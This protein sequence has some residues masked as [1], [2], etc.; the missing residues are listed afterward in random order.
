MSSGR[1]WASPGSPSPIHG[2]LIASQHESSGLYVDPT[3]FPTPHPLP[4]ESISPSLANDLLACQLRVAFSRD[5]ELRSWRRPSTYSALGVAAHWVTE[6]AF[7]RSHWPTDAVQVRNRLVEL[8]DGEIERGASALANAWAPAIPP[9]PN[10]WPGYSLTR[11]RTI[12]RAVKLLTSRSAGS[13]D[14]I[15][16]TGIEIELTDAESGL[17]GRAD[18]IDRDGSATR[19]VDLKTGLRQGAPTDD[20]RRQLLLYA[21]LA[22]RATG[23]WPSS[24]AV[25]DASGFQYVQELSAPQAED[26]LQEV[27]SARSEFNTLTSTARFTEVAQPSADRCRWCAFR[28]V[29]R[30]YWQELRAD[31]QHRSVMGRIV[32]TGFADGTGHLS[33]SIESPADQSNRIVHLS[34]ASMAPSEADDKAAIVDWMG[35]LELGTVR[36]RW[37]TSLRT[38]RA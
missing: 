16:G 30:P 24:I 2:S 12:R 13:G 25:E 8:W 5:P 37:S 14:R 1:T 7:K 3:D 34:S 22:Q 17:S 19:I 33:I 10:E 18:R 23:A 4:I 9:P 35:N 26:V 31:W 15:P 20:Q 29:C 21:V 27:E 28:V 38:W 32:E 36:A 11:A 6:K